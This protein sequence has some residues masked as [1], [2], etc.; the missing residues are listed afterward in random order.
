MKK[1]VLTI[2][3]DKKL[4]HIAPE[5]YGQFSEHLGRCIYDG[6][7]VGESSDIPNTNGMRN[8]IVDALRNLNLP[9]LR[10]PGGCFAD[11]YHWKDGIGPKENRR[12]I[13]NSNWG[14][15]VEDNSFGTHEFMEL[16][17]QIDC[18]PYIAIN[19]G[20]GT[21]Q[22][23]ADWVEYMTAKDTSSLA[24]LRKE[25]G[26]E[27]PWKVKYIGIGNEN[28]GCGGSMSADYYANEYKRYQQFCKPY[29]GNALYKIACGPSADDYC[30]TRELMSRINHFHANG[31]S[32]HYYTIPT[33]SFEKKGS[34]INFTEK[35][36]YETIFQTLRMEEIINGHLRV[37]DKFD[38]EH[39][40]DLIVDEWGTW[41]DEEP[42]ADSGVL[43]QQNTMRDAIVAA[44]N[45]NIFN[46]HSDRIAMANIAQVVNVL[47]AMILT[48][49]AQIIKTPTYE[50]FNMY[51]EHQN[52]TLVK[53]SIDALSS[54]CD[55]VTIPALSES[56][57]ISEAD[58]P[59]GNGSKKI[60]I[61]V[62]NASL[63][64]DTEI[65]LCLPETTQFIGEATISLLHDEVHSYNTFG[66]PEKVK[67]AERKETWNG[68][69]QIIT[70]PACSICKVH[71]TVCI[72]SK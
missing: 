26:Q 66:Q 13:I 11:E 1:A 39:K 48:D 33:G 29:S 16:C 38:P 53:S 71:C 8:D 63:A 19:L 69:K 58:S 60:T 10:W 30:W 51:K 21:I 59:S 72:T 52:A 43:Y 70:L 64:D 6:V 41:Y 31:I 68:N 12:K 25:N 67:A 20:S 56:V 36:Y 28:W 57:S 46:K 40:I 49:G 27:E 37:M 24:E 15:F 44:L 2:H 35:E 23:A 55:G 61:T 45:L 62:A 4:S 65:E 54:G 47:Q 34:A 18:E 5:L 17:R 50:V 9:V 22:E 32:L 3:P 7:F 42:G 14:G